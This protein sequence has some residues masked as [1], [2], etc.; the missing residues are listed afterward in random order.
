[1]LS[2]TGPESFPSEDLVTVARFESPLEAQLAR[3]LLESAGIA[4]FLV[5][6]N[7]N[8]MLQ[9]A[10]GVHLQ[11]GADDEVSARELLG[12]QGGSPGDDPRG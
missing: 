2:Q 8:H 11:V 3:G 10:F 1:M 4:S 6:E 5:G 7:V 9:A 12:T